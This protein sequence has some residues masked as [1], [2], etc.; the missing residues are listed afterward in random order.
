MRFYLIDH[1]GNVV[2]RF[3]HVFVHV[4][5]RNVTRIVDDDCSDL[6]ERFDVRRYLNVDVS[7]IFRQQVDV[8]WDH[9]VITNNSAFHS[10]S[11]QSSASVFWKRIAHYNSATCHVLW[12][13][14]FARLTFMPAP[15]S[16]IAIAGRVYH[17]FLNQLM[18]QRL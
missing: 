2:R 12:K 18:Q 15:G 16:Y 5:A 8:E 11:V 3:Q 14:T 7:G 9:P 6:L 13:P 10:A 1:Y 4:S 17:E